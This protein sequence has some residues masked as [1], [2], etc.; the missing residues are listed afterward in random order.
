MSYPGGEQLVLDWSV[1]WAQQS[2]FQIVACAFVDD[3]DVEEL[4]GVPAQRWFG[5]DGDELDV[6]VFLGRE[7]GD[8]DFL[9]SFWSSTGIDMAQCSEL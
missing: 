1:Q 7:A 5:A 4:F 9:A 3:E 2:V 8:G 6:A